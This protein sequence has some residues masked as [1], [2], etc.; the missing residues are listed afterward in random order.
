VDTLTQSYR[1]QGRSL[2]LNFRFEL[3]E[4]T[5]FERL[6]LEMKALPTDDLEPVKPEE[7]SGFWV[8]LQDRRGRP[9][10]RR[11][12]PHPMIRRSEAHGDEPGPRTVIWVEERGAF[13]VVVPNLPAGAELVMFGSPT[14]KPEIPAPAAEILRVTLREER[15]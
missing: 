2:R 3:G 6:G 7:R 10:Y 13:S 9:L 4:I 12:L 5:L 1:R 14:D 8:E 15:S 11:S